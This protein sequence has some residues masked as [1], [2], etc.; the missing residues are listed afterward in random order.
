MRCVFPRAPQ[1]RSMYLRR[2]VLC[3]EYSW[4]CPESRVG[5]SHM[6]SACSP[7]LIFKFNRY[8]LQYSS[9]FLSIT[10]VIAS[11]I[12]SFLELFLFLIFSPI[13][14]RKTSPCSGELCCVS[15]EL[16]GAFGHPYM[17]VPV[18]REPDGSGDQET[19]SEVLPMDGT[20]W[21]THISKSTS[22]KKLG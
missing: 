14:K 22:P 10:A 11:F 5:I 4:G 9:L 15:D 21:S 12:V 16:F 2:R 6:V 17:G 20:F 8:S 7:Y 3:R 18:V 19:T 1:S 13:S